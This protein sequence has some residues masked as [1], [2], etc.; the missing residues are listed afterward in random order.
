MD[1]DWVVDAQDPSSCYGRYINENFDESRVNCR[2]VLLRRFR[3]LAVVAIPR[4]L[5][6]RGQELYISYGLSYWRALVGHLGPL[7]RGA[8]LQ[9][10]GGMV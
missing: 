5:I 9:E 3:R 7:Q 4:I 2:I 8:L 10:P 1:A 6:R